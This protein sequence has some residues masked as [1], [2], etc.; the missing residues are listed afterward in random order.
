MTD[1]SPADR[2]QFRVVSFPASLDRDPDLLP[3]TPL[4][5]TPLIGR[6]QD[7]QTVL[8]LLRRDDMPLVTLTGPGGVGKSR[9]ALQVAASVANEFADGVC[10]VELGS[11]RDPGLVLPT[12]ANA[13]GLSDVGNRPL[14]EQ[15]IS[16]LRPRQLLLVLDNLEQVVAAAPEVANLL[17][18]CPRLKVLATSR[19]VLRLSIE[20]DVPVEPLPVPAAVQLFVTRANAASR[21]FAL[22]AENA[23]TVAAVCARL[24][25]LPLAIEL[26][27]ARVRALAPAALLTRLEHALPLL[28]GGARDRPDRLRTMRAA[29]A[30]SYDLLGPL[31]QV[32]FARLAVFAGGF[33]LPSAEAVCALLSGEGRTPS[34]A[35]RLPPSHSMLDVIQLL[36]DNSLLRQVGGPEAEE[37]RYR[38]LE[39][40][41]EYG[42]ERLAA[43]DEEREVRAAHATYVL[44]MVEQEF[45]RLLTAGYKRVIARLEAEHDDVR[46]ALAW[47]EEAGEDEIGLRLAGA[48]AQFWTLRGHLQEGRSRME[49]ALRRGQQAPTPARAR[50]LV[51]AGWL[52]RYQGDVDASEAW[53]LEA[54]DVARIVGDRLSEAR[55]LRGL[56]Q[57]DLERGTY[58]RA[59]A[60]TGEALALFQ[61]HERSV[62]GGPQ[63]V[64]ATYADLGKIALARGDAAGA[65]AHLEEALRRQRALGYG[66]GLGDTLRLLGDLARDRGDYEGALACY[67]ESLTVAEDHGDARYLSQPVTG[68]ASVAV[69][70]GQPDRAARLYGAAAALRKEIGVPVAAWERLTYERNVAAARVALS[71]EVF[72]AAWAAGEALPFASIITETLATHADLRS[73]GPQSTTPVGSDPVAAGNLSTREGEVLRFLAQG[74]SDREIAEELFLSPRTVSSHVSHLLAKLGVASRSAAAAFAVRHGLDEPSRSPTA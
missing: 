66:W 17:T 32:L 53:L 50:G 61:E 71:P 14:A 18:L 42:L 69:L 27:A 4:P 47:A 5:R 72:T 39:T 38:M 30:W 51:G 25:G 40:V 10:F 62:A 65:T 31:E 22:T 56:G 35:F 6:D 7:V 13:L 60:R 33:E 36:V 2:T 48:A 70:F 73:A 8:S 43:S 21:E 46:A 58:E 59:A 11:L 15:L 45:E 29:I 19:V 67:G 64:S 63:Y 3:P 74:L 26:A 1:S 9:I 23:A 28:T 54:L 37:P 12:I 52:A 44:G 41:R 24:D 20:Q 57:T 34:P 68:V 55:A 16:H 49:R